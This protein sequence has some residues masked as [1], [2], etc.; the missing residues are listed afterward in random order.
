M[1]LIRIVTFLMGIIIVIPNYACTIFV[2]TDS[3]R[4]LF[5]NNEDYSNPS[6]RIW[7]LPG[8]KGQYGRAY[9]GFDNGWA[10]GGVNTEG[11]AFDWVAGSKVDYTP[12]E[13]LQK[14]KGN[15][16]EKMM[17]TCATVAEAIAFYQKYQEPGFSYAKIMIADKTGRSVII[18]A[19]NGKLFFDESQKSRGFGY[20]QK[21]LGKQLAKA[22]T[23]TLQSGLPIL[24][25]CRQEGQYATKY[26]TVYDLRSGEIYVLSSNQENQ[27]NL[28]L[29][30]ELDK[31]GHY[32]DIPSLSSQLKQPPIDIRPEMMQ[33]VFDGYPSITDLEPAITQRFRTLFENSY[34]GNIKAGEFSPEL[35]KQIA[36][37]LKDIEADFKKHGNI[38]SFSLVER[39]E[40]E[41]QRS[42]RYLIEYEYATVLQRFVLNDK[43]QLSL[44][45]GE[46]W[47]WKPK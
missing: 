37:N 5:F 7:F 2:L 13:K 14:V 40:V 45:K 43:N 12:D 10:Q 35:W 26:S 34:S 16:S 24:E 1:M 38:K 32:Y 21:A 22:P 30:S 4:T 3:Q 36:P 41:G 29:L 44:V 8:V 19:E 31:G 33:F 6:T 39:K 15:P 9:V 47:E 20:G 46:L 25:A 11:L 18:G 27:V 42:Y 28:N 17:Q 23:A